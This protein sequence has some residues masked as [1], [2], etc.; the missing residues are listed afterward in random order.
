VPCDVVAYHDA[1]IGRPAALY[2]GEPRG[3]VTSALRAAEIRYMHQ[4]PLKPVDGARKFSDFLTRRE[5]HRLDYYQE[6]A[7]PLG[8]EDMIRLWLDPDGARLEFDRP[9]RT[10]SERD[11]AVLDL[12]LEHF[13]QFRGLALGRSGP[14][15]GVAA[16]V[17]T[18]RELQVLSLIAQGQT[19]AQV[20]RELWISPGTVRKHLDNVYSKLGVHTRAA[21]VASLFTN[22]TAEVDRGGSQ[23][24]GSSF[25]SS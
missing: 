14:T 5:F 24:G 22:V 8:V 17:L 23:W 2:V 19:N 15:S 6:V 21:A 11:R 16:L 12:L 1:P 13:K 10:F 20:A 25:R 18:A 4:D 7:R 3:G 9:D